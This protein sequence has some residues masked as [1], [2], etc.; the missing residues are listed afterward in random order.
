MLKPEKTGADKRAQRSKSR[1]RSKTDFRKERRD[2]GKR[3]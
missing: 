2:K 3:Q 1:E